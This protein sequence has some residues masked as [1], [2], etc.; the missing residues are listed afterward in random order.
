MWWNW[1]WNQRLKTKPI[2]RVGSS[3]PRDLTIGPQFTL[4][5]LFCLTGYQNEQFFYPKRWTCM[6]LFYFKFKDNTFKIC[7]SFNSLFIIKLWLQPTSKVSIVDEKTGIVSYAANWFPPN[8]VELVV[9][10]YKVWEKKITVEPR[11]SRLVGTSVKSPHN[12]ESTM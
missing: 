2:F 11:L 12:R 1:S 4:C 9:T 5:H 8:T 10:L 7:Y 6:L 3:K